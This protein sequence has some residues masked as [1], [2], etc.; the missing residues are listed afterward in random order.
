MTIL[1]FAKIDLPLTHIYFSSFS[2]TQIA[3]F[4]VDRAL[5][6]EIYAASKAGE[7]MTRFT[8]GQIEAYLDA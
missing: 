2:Q 1:Q 4:E 5:L 7:D 6:N 8:L 3:V